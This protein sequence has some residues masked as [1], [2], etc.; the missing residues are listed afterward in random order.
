MRF[1]FVF[2][3]PSITIPQSVTSI[4]PGAFFACAGLNSIIVEEGNPVYHSTDNCLI[5]TESKTLLLGCLNSRI[6]QDGSV[7]SIAPGAFYYCRSLEE[8][9]IPDGITSIGE[10]AFCDC[11]QLKAIHLPRSVTSIGLS[12]FELCDSLTSISVD[13]E[14]PIYHADGNCLIETESKTLL[15][16][17][18][19]S[20]VPQ[21][22]SVTR[23]G[24]YAFR[25]CESLTSFVIPNGITEI[26]TQAFCGCSNLTSITIPESV[27][28]IG[29]YAFL[30]CSKLSTIYF[31]GTKAEWQAIGKGVEWGNQTITVKCTDGDITVE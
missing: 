17:C 24:D 7:T 28:S 27:A 18:Q 30:N 3:I 12:A 13:P 8:I 2:S 6:P 11:R 15:L 20:I 23:I 25:N 19:S 9:V 26:G 31:D 14:N 10:S 1:Y 16:G 5:E 4:A 29:D 21:D 22:G